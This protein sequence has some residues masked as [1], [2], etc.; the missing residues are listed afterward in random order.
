MGT[1]TIMWLFLGGILLMA[2]LIS[3]LRGDKDA[4]VRDASSA[5]A[6]RLTPERLSD[7]RPAASK[8]DTGFSI[9]PI[10]GLRRKDDQNQS[11][12]K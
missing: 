6:V 5:A 11:Y 1:R 9:D 8:V 4:P 7:A 3:S 10:K 2:G 12:F